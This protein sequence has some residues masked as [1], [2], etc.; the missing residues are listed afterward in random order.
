MK[1]LVG[2]SL[3]EKVD[4][5]G[6]KVEVKK[7]SVAEVLELQKVITKANKSKDEDAQV[8]LLESV[9]K[10]AVIDSQD[11]TSEEFQQFPIGELNRLSEEILRLAGLSGTRGN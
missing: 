3:T 2:K 7:L 9:I 11:I 1:H 5:M 4:F 10:T 6:D 8:K